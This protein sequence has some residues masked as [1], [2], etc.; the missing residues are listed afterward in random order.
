MG[1][2]SLNLNNLCLSRAII[3]VVS[4]E[5]DEKNEGGGGKWHLDLGGRRNE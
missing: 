4:F 1:P 2:H 3:D 5:G